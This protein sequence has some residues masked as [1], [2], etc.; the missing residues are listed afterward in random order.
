MYVCF[1]I[2][3]SPVSEFWSVMTMDVNT[4]FN[5]FSGQMNDAICLWLHYKVIL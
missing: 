5:Y 2:K 4:R 3:K 1:M